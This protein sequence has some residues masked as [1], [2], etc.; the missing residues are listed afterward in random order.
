MLTGGSDGVRWDDIINGP[1]P[2]HSARLCIVCYIK[3]LKVADVI[4]FR[5]PITIFSF[6]V[7]G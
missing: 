5:L 7:C 6:A 2:N 1:G 3:L 4:V